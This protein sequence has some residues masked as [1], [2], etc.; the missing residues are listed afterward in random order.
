MAPDGLKVGLQ[1]SRP[2]P[3]CGQGRDRA[4]RQFIDDQQQPAIQNGILVGL[5]GKL[6]PVVARDDHPA[7]FENPVVGRKDQRVWAAR[8][9]ILGCVSD[10]RPPQASRHQ[11]QRCRF[12]RPSQRAENQNGWAI[13]QRANS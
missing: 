9:C 5:Q 3:D 7:I 4:Q 11:R 8:A 10:T 2:F 6:L 12:I 1:L 13:G